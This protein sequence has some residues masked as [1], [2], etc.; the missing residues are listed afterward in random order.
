MTEI[1]CA[2]TS[3]LREHRSRSV[4][5]EEEEDEEEAAA[6]REAAGLERTQ[7]SQPHASS[8]APLLLLSAV[9]N[10]VTIFI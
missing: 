7:Q 9:E 8:W 10:I 1:I 3:A 2:A 5:E 6:P 4:E